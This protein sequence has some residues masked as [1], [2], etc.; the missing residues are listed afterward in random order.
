[1][2]RPQLADLDTMHSTTERRFLQTHEWH[3]LDDDVVTIGI[4]Q[5]AVDELTD[6]T[7]V[8]ITATQGEVRAGESIGEIESVKATSDIYCGIDGTVLEINQAVVDDPSL[9]NQSP[10]EEGWLIKVRMS[11]VSQ[12]ENLMTAE[13][14]DQSTG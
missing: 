10:Y 14:Y 7:Y 6:I 3:R 1:M 9:I 12:L 2:F 13:E 4:S 11:D 5:F 8:E